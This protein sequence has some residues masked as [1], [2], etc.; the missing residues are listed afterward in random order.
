MR[1][2]TEMNKRGRPRQFDEDAVNEAMQDL[3]LRQGFAATSLDDIAKV[4]SLNRPSLY[5]AF[6]NKE[7]MYLGCLRH[8]TEELAAELGGVF[9]EAESFEAA[10]WGFYAGLI[11]YYYEAG[12]DR[13]LGCLVF[14]NAIADAPS[15]DQI[16]A[17]LG[18][19]LERVR[20]AITRCV[21]KHHPDCPD[22]QLNAATELALSVF[23]SL[24]TRTRSG[25]ERASVECATRASVKAIAG[26]VG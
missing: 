10:L 1:N 24:G 19:T 8:R 3:F 9:V 16:R 17:Y 22:A 7:D 5:R 25:Q 15:N 12:D 26:L 21:Q 4:T 6:G 14:S 11:E 13:G 23:L 20:R 18:E 2:G